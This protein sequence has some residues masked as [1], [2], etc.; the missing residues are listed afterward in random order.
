[1]TGPRGVGIKGFSRGGAANTDQLRVLWQLPQS[2][3]VFTCWTCL[4]VAVT[5]LWQLWQ[6][7]LIPR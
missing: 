2:R 6:L 4:P 7:A 3:V 5:P 1:M